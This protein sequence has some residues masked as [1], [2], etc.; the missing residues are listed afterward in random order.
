MFYKQPYLNRNKR[1]FTKASGLAPDYPTPQKTSDLLFYIQRNHNWNTVIYKVN[2]NEDGKI[3]EDAPMHIQ[4]IMYN[5]S[6]EVEELTYLQNKLAYG[7]QF[8]KINEDSYEFHF[9]SFPEMKFYLGLCPKTKRYATY[10]KRNGNLIELS[11]V[12]V[13]ADEFGL[14]PDV[15]FIEFYGTDVETGKK[16][17]QKL[18]L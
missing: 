11:N 10:H 14:F 6:G 9:V 4:W 17:L 16:V 7:C 18:K 12:Y 1:K 8:E 2:L 3:I 5:K 13:H 15:K